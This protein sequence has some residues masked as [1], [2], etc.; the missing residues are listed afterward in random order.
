[1]RNI[2]QKRDALFDCDDDNEHVVCFLEYQL[3]KVRH[4]GVY[5]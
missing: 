5:N 4:A 3:W 2:L 1:M